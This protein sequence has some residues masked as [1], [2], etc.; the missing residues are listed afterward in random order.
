MDRFSL[1]KLP[2]IKA[3]SKKAFFKKKSGAKVHR[4]LESFCW[5][6]GVGLLGYAL[7]MKTLEVHASQEGIAQ[8]Q[9][10]LELAQNETQE[11]PAPSSFVVVMDQPDTSSLALDD[12]KLNSIDKSLWNQKRINQFNEIQKT[13]KDTPIALLQ[14]EN[15][16]ILAPVYNNT[17]DFNLNRGA[18]WIENTAMINESG[19][20]GIAAHRDSFFRGLKDIKKGH[21]ISLQTLSGKRFFTVTET[22]IVEQTQVDVLGPTDNNQLTL[23]TCYPFYYVGSAPQ[24]FIV[25]AT[26][27]LSLQPR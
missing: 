8:F 16:N 6:F 23:V 27:D 19:N 1:D 13:N 17:S 26:E 11:N 21:Q 20:I 22:K 18:G 4:A 5:V 9:S 24:R 10:A 7:T 14:I 3:P 25:T 2:L 12:K 15:V